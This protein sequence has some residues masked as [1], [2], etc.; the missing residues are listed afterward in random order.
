MDPKD[1]PQEPKEGLLKL[2]QELIDDDFK[3]FKY[4]LESL[5]VTDGK[6]KVPRGPLDTA[7]RMGTI[8]LMLSHHGEQ[9]ALQITAEILKTIPRNDLL[10]RVE[11]LQSYLGQMGKWSPAQIKENKE[12]FKELMKRRFR[13]MEDESRLPGERVMLQDSYTKLIILQRHRPKEER[14]DEIMASGRRHLELMAER[15]SDSYSSIQDLFKPEKDGHIPSTVVL[16]GVA[17]I[18]KTMTAQKILLDWAS[19]HLFQDKFQYVFYIQCREVNQLGGQQTI[20]DIIVH[21]C[22]GKPLLTMEAI[23]AE[24]Q[25]VLFIIDGFDELK[26]PKDLPRDDPSHLNIRVYRRFINAILYH[27]SYPDKNPLSHKSII[28]LLRRRYLPE[29]FLLITTRPTA[30][31]ALTRYLVQCGND[32]RFAEILGFSEEDRKEYFNKFFGNESQ[33]SQAFNVVKENELLYTMCFVPIVCW[34]V[35]KAIKQQME[36]REEFVHLSKSTTSVYL[37][38]LSGLLVQQSTGSQR[39]TVSNNL[40]RLCALAYE[41]I[42]QQKI[43][44]EEE[45][46]RRHGVDIQAV[47]SLFLTNDLF[48]KDDTRYNLYSFLHLSFQE[49]FAALYFILGEDEARA[50][51]TENLRAQVTRLLRDYRRHGHLTLTVRFLFGLLNSDL[52]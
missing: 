10:P 20:E 31:E 3:E 2:L 1:A 25:K 40:K 8:K 27:I 7:D 37:L 51:H 49:F 38:F 34:I 23:E 22:G 9:S 5:P 39:S 11:I 41:G 50:E 35:C 14:E 48:R 16:Q 32:E 45:D 46:L 19:G 44:F 6:S 47:Q 26:L 15:A 43:L 29:S 36:T 12:K 17:G 33:G 28:H 30:L 52:Q 42:C 13:A 24:P 4:H 18:G 21:I